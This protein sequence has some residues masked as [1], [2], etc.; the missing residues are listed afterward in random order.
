MPRTRK[1]KFYTSSKIELKDTFGPEDVSDS[2]GEQLGQPGAFPYTRGVQETMY[3]GRL[4]TMRQYAGFGSARESNERYR[5]L[6][7]K[8]TTGLSIAFDLPTQM[9][10]DS[11]HIMA[12]GEVGKVGVEHSVRQFQRG[13]FQSKHGVPWIKVVCDIGVVDI[14]YVGPALRIFDTPACRRHIGDQ[15]FGVDRDTKPLP[16]RIHHRGR[17]VTLPAVDH[18]FVFVIV[19]VL[20][21]P[22]ALH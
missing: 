1:E 2:A 18:Q 4:W 11:D 21:H 22:F 20:F 13:I 17:F 14:Q 12:S 19:S 9:G 7:D 5:L 16:K 3:R 15:G 10:Y 8:G 6:L